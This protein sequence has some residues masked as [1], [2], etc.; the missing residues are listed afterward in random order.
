MAENVKN[1]ERFRK[2]INLI[3]HVCAGSQII[4]MLMVF[5]CMLY[6]AC[7]IFE[8]HL[9]D[10]TEPFIEFTKSVT[11]FFFGDTIQ[12]NTPDVDGK[13]V[14]FVL[15]NIL[16]AFFVSQ[17][18]IACISF[19]KDIDKRIVEAKN[20]IEKQF[21]E[22]LQAKMRQDIMA[23]SHYIIA[24]QFHL[25]FLMAD[26]F[27][28]TAPTEEEMEKTKYDVISK[29]FEQIKM[30]PDLRFTKDGEILLISSSNIKNVDDVMNKMWDTFETI[31]AEYKAQKFGVRI[32]AAI[33]SFRS[34]D[35]A[36][37][38]YKQIRPLLDLNAVNEMLCFGNFRNRYELIPDNN[39]IIAIKGKYDL[40]TG[41]EES[42][43]YL[44]KKD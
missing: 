43:W 28:I 35:S 27:G 11:V 30:L 16:L 33:Q 38:A 26:G 34:T 40:K 18:K 29:F 17:L 12:S 41:Q 10:F 32:R 14:L 23:Q 36:N 7:G 8:V 9:L 1:L 15:V 19:G 4:I 20:A 3:V 21:N 31:R 5:I 39:Y 42:V 22:T 6:I 24:V 37:S 2:V 25:R 44:V 13:I